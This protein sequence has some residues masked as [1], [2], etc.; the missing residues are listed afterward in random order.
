MAQAASKDFTFLAIFRTL[1]GAAEATADPA[2]VLITSTWY[3]RAQQPSRIGY[4]YCAN[5]FGIALGGLL[6]YGIG[7]IKAA[8]APWKYEFLIVG[9]ICSTWAVVLFIL[10]PDSPYNTHWFTRTERLII[11][12]RK[13][14][15][16]SGPDRRQ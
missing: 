14:D 6:G 4:W 2:F 15:D 10:V 11:V 13:R 9:A 5:G 16:Q 7:H 1:S 12:S 8:L 3:T